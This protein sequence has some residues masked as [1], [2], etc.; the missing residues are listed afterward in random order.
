[1]F[2]VAYTNSLYEHHDDAIFWCQL[3]LHKFGKSQDPLISHCRML[4]GKS[5]AWKYS[6]EQRQLEF[7]MDFFSI[8][9]LKKNE[10]VKNCYAKA[11][12]AIFQLGYALDNGILDEEGSMLLDFSMI[13]YSREVNA[14]NECN[15]CL[16]C[17][18]W[19]KLCRSHICPEA[20]LKEIAKEE[21]DTCVP[22]TSMTG[23]HEVKSTKRETKWLLCHTCEQLLS[24][25]GETQF[26]EKFFRIL[27]P[28]I[29]SHSISYT[30][31]LYN[32]CTGVA[33]RSLCLTNFSD[34]HNRNEIYNFFVACRNHLLSLSEEISQQTPCKTQNELEF[35]LF[36]NPVGLY[37]VEE[38]WE[39]IL[40]GILQSNFQVHISYHHLHN[41]HKSL[42][43]EGCFFQLIL[44]GITM[45]AKF[46]PDQDFIM[47]Q[48]FVQISKDGGEY[49]VFDEIQRWTDIPQGV[50][51]IIKESVISV[52]SR[53]SE[54]FWGKVPLSKRYKS[55]QIP[56]SWNDEITQRTGPPLPDALVDL[57]KSI[58]SGFTE[59]VTE[60]NLLPEGFKIS[61]EP[62]SMVILPSGHIVLKHAY[63]RGKDAT[64][65]LGA[66]CHN[67]DDDIYAI[68]VQRKSQRELIYGFHLQ[69]HGEQY[70]I[71]KLLVT[72]SVEGADSAFLGGVVSGI[73]DVLESLWHDFGSLQGIIHHSEIK[74][75]VS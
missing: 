39:D 16:L 2:I 46:S 28:T 59:T 27:Y 56:S 68:V 37:S 71:K 6:L 50:M 41:G 72:S 73:T 15:R 62:V 66:D 21:S 40:S 7:E 35:F 29:K 54:V 3:M 19:E 43:M 22:V 52:R 70:T 17:R 69:I 45:L 8:S 47:P 5:F 11:R 13:D 53:I 4:L 48:S 44:G 51:E 24:R 42:I 12:N 31:E 26:T 57:Q 18:K 34:L 74:R 25:H 65:L 58:L 38:V 75:W 64:L 20:I 32:F 63:S 23:R 36:R 14:L 33:F 49:I 55:T 1:M 60:V 61:R 67:S 30:E 10:A 9:D